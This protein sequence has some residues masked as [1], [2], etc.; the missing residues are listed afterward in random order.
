MGDLP[1]AM[2]YR[3]HVR[4]DDRI[5]AI[6]AG[7]GGAAHLPGM[8]Q[9]HSGT[10]ARGTWE[11]VNNVLVSGAIPRWQKEMLFVAISKDRACRYCT[12]AHIASCRMLGVKPELL[13]GLVRDMDHIP[14]T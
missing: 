2:A 7:A 13:E 12:A 3:A 1:C 11:L 10:V 5:M 4:I 9:G 14:D 6:I 8:T